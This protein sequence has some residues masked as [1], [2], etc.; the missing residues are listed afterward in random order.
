MKFL[1]RTAFV[2]FLWTTM[3]WAQATSQ[4]TGTVHDPSGGA[5]PGATVRVTQTDTGFT[6]SMVTSSQG[7]YVLPNL[8]VGPYRL[9]VTKDGFSKYVEANLVLEVNVNP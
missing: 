7:D 6:S 9:E 2:A 4:I 3:V 1:V 5:I 8:P